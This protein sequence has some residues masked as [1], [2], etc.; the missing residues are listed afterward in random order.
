MTVDEHL[1]FHNHD[2]AT[3]SYSYGRRASRILNPHL[4]RK[5]DDGGLVGRRQ[6]GIAPPFHG[7]ALRGVSDRSYG[8]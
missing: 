6:A 7:V 5:P 2:P 8:T 3:T 1:R 4:I